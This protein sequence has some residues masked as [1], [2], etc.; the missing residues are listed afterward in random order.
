MCFTCHLNVTSCP[1]ILGIGSSGQFEL[2]PNLMRIDKS[3]QG[4]TLMVCV[5]TYV[6]CLFTATWCQ[7]ICQMLLQISSNFYNPIDVSIII[8]MTC[9]RKF[10][11]VEPNHSLEITVQR[12]KLRVASHCHC[13]W[14]HFCS[15]AGTEEEVI[16]WITPRCLSSLSLSIYFY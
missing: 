3:Q 15:Q 12:F 7:A 14:N 1:Q 16:N 2:L 13:L 4:S 5:C 11:I 6:Y 10:R 8:F 9:K